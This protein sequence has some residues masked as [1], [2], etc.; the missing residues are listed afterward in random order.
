[1][2]ITIREAEVKASLRILEAERE[3][4]QEPVFF[5]SQP[6]ELNEEAV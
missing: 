1:M 6:S 4:A 5:C 2:N 3:I